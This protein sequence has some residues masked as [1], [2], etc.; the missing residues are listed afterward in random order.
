[1]DEIYALPVRHHALALHVLFL[2][3]EVVMNLVMVIPIVGVVAMGDVD[4]QPE[5]VIDLS[6][7]PAPNRL[8]AGRQLALPEEDPR[9]TKEGELVTVDAVSDQGVALLVRAGHTVGRILHHALDPILGLGHILHIHGIREAG[10]VGVLVAGAG[11][12]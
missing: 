1:M 8:Y 11:E 6:P 3:A 5:T 2:A 12:A 7:G 4:H 9:A 10:A